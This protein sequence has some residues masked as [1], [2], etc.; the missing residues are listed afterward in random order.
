MVLGQVYITV[1]LQA[2][3]AACIVT[4]PECRAVAALAMNVYGL[5][6]TVNRSPLPRLAGT[7]TQ[8]RSSNGNS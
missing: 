1:Q 5:R 8:K 6:S 2:D 3:K 4:A 7:E